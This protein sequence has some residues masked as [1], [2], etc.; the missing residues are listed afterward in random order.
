[1]GCSVF[2]LRLGRLVGW[3]CSDFRLR[4]ALAAGPSKQAEL[5]NPEGQ[6]RSHFGPYQSGLQK[7]LPESS[8]LGIIR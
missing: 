8:A 3:R 5:T 4:A 7:Q 1:M 2:R 6:K